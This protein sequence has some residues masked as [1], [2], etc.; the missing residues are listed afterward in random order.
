MIA[1]I[2]EAA[3][4]APLEQLAVSPQV[5]LVLSLSDFV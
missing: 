3:K 4:Y 5:N 2:K 1:R